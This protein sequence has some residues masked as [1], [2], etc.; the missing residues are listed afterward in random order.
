MIIRDS[1]LW[2]WI[3][4][5]A[6]LSCCINYS[7]PL[8]PSFLF[9]WIYWFCHNQQMEM[10]YILI[11][12]SIYEPLQNSQQTHLADVTWKHSCGFYFDETTVNCI[13]TCCAAPLLKTLVI[14]W[15]NG[16]LVDAQCHYFH[17]HAH[18]SLHTA[19]Y[20]H[21]K[22]LFFMINGKRG[23]STAASLKVTADA[24]QRVIN[25]C[26]GMNLFLTLWTGLVI[27]GCV[28]GCEPSDSA[29]GNVH[30]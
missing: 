4:T 1:C 24:F 6:G 18:Y 21:S 8:S 20:L 23:G 28:S 30:L 5:G 7:K 11:H 14:T 10:K 3:T 13:V 29:T 16:W 9:A 26:L 22:L 15:T 2:Q 25:M 27:G 19:G 17:S 12:S